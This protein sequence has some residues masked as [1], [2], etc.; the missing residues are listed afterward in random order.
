[1]KRVQV[2]GYSGT[3]KTTLAKELS[4]KLNC[5]HVELDGLFWKED[6]QESSDDEFMKSVKQA[7][8]PKK[9]VIDGDYTNRLVG[10]TLQLTDTVIVLRYSPWV[11][12]PRLISRGIRRSLSGELLWG[13]NKETLR[14]QI[15]LFKFVFKEYLKE[16]RSRSLKKVEARNFKGTVI[17]LDNPK[18]VAVWLKTI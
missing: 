11:F 16:G 3:G 18:E 6:W 7:L 17:I 10:Y 2:I 15:G 14:G 1:M 12:M 13:K 4:K 5:T 8:K 9:W